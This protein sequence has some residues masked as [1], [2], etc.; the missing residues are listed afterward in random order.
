MNIEEINK[1][2]DMAVAVFN[3]PSKNTA[4]QKNVQTTAVCM[5][6]VG[7]KTV[8][9]TV[10]DISWDLYYNNFP[11]TTENLQVRHHYE[12]LVKLK[13]G[14]EKKCPEWLGIADFIFFIEKK[15]TVEEITARQYHFRDGE[16]I[17]EEEKKYPFTDEL[18]H[19]AYNTPCSKKEFFLTQKVIR[20]LEE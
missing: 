9:I 10:A 6:E 3:T 18:R 4:P 17:L 19:L 11:R 1:N 20:D 14:T 8:G 2:E 15:E 7:E 5:K 16:W 12:Y 13:N